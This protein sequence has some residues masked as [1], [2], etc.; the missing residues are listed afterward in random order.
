MANRSRDTLGRLP[1]PG[2]YTGR[3]IDI[4]AGLD[5]T[6]NYVVC[7][8]ITV[9]ALEL[10]GSTLHRMMVTCTTGFGTL[11]R[12]SHHDQGCTCTE[13][14]GTVSCLPYLHCPT[15]AMAST[16]YGTCFDFYAE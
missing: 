2:C 15:G 3:L 7:I 16:Y 5:G 1:Q 9:G 8:C 13:G 4:F 11:V 14:G 6:S 12:G 10:A